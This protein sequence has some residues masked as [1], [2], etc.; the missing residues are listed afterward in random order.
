M[1][2]MASGQKLTAIG[3][4]FLGK[5]VLYEILLTDISNIGAVTFNSLTGKYFKLCLLLGIYEMSG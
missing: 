3:H 4:E 1:M 2:M 5:H